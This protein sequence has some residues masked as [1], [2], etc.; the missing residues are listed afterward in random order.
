MFV[1]N[2][3]GI[4]LI[5]ISFKAY[6]LP[7]SWNLSEVEIG[8][9]NII[10]YIYHSSTVGTQ[11]GTK[12]EKVITGLRFVCSTINNTSESDSNSIIAVYWDG[13]FGNNKHIINVKV[14]GKP[15]LVSSTWNQDG[16]L[17]YRNI[18]ESTE[19]IESLTKG[20]TVSIDWTVDSIKKATV[21]SLKDFNS[22]FNKFKLSCG[23]K[24]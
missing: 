7:L 24:T 15:V 10:G 3:F 21:F 17:L 12:K 16:P 8:S 22:G 18:S 2:L 6:S 20:K 19:L 13:M 23:I 14:D 5:F 4:I 1:R 11:I 9:K